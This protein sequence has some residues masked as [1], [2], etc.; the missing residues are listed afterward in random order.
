M[1]WKI[2]LVWLI[3][4]TSILWYVLS[5]KWKTLDEFE[6]VGIARFRMMNPIPGME[7]YMDLKFSVIRHALCF[8]ISS[9]LIYY[10]NLSWIIY[11]VMAV[12]ALYTLLPVLRYMNRK[13][14]LEER[15]RE[16]ENSSAAVKY[17][18]I[19]VK[20]SFC[21]VVYSVLSYVVLAA[22]MFIK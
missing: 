7:N 11:I 21:T 4:A 10:V 19:P 16:S 5:E 1:Y 22:L 12:N 18:S 14:Y 2:A 3:A 15:S 9:L 20:D 8:L 17:M 13:R 6:K